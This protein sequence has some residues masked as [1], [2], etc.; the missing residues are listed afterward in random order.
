MDISRRLLKE[1]EIHAYAGDIYSWLD[2][3]IRMLEAVQRIAYAFNRKK[4]VLE[5]NRLIKEIEN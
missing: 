2:S 4:V 1:F 5:C 3:V